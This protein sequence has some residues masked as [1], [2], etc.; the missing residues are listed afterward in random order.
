MHGKPPLLRPTPA[1]GP[2]EGESA[3]GRDAATEGPE[4]AQLLRLLWRRRL[5]ILAVALLGAL[6]V[7]ALVVRLEP[8]YRA[9]AV[10]LFQPAPQS[11][12]AEA[13]GL[14]LPGTADRRHVASEIEL[15]RSRGL[16]ERVIRREG[17]LYRAEF[18]P[19][20]D[21]AAGPLRRLGLR[22]PPGPETYRLSR[23]RAATLEALR[24]R[25]QVRPLGDSRAVEIAA[26]SRDPETAA[27]IAN[28]L[29]DTYLAETAAR[30]RDGRSAT[31]AW[32]DGRVA[33]LRAR[34]QTAEAAVTDF[35]LE[36]GLTGEGA[37]DTLDAERLSQLNSAVLEAAAAR[38]EAAARLAEAERLLDTDGAASAA[39]VLGSQLIRELRRQESELLRRRAELAINYGHRHPRMLTVTAELTDLRGKIDREVG[40]VVQHLRN[41][42][43]VARRREAE[44][45]GRLQAAEAE[46]AQLSRARVRLAQLEREA[47][48]ERQL[49]ETFLARL[50]ETRVVEDAPR[51]PAKVISRALPP[52]AP[53]APN[54]A[55]LLGFGALTALACGIALAVLVEALDRGVR[56]LPQLERLTGQRALALV[57]TVYGR[58]PPAQSVLS[59][60]AGAFAEALRGLHTALLLHDVDRPPGTLMLTSALPQEG[61]TTLACALA[62]LLARSGSRVLLVDADLRHPGVARTL[63]LPQG[64]GLAE[65]LAGTCHPAQAIRP[66]PAPETGGRLAVLTAG[67]AGA[68]GPVLESDALAKLLA[69][70]SGVYDLVLI[71]APPALA[72]AD[73]R[74]LA[75][76]VDATVLTVRWA[77]TPRPTVQHAVAQLTQAGATLAGLA[78]TRVDLRRHAR[79]GGGDSAPYARNGGYYDGA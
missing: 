7:G 28:A 11:G 40:R 79:Y 68:P 39:E 38:A 65:V 63:Y 27:G 60:P 48:A 22:A 55:L 51:A 10:L 33:E 70:W 32:L 75:H 50:K 66:D 18:N 17:L 1:P 37:G 73:S 61:K 24:S 6:V 20:L 45:S 8:R 69:A 77:T 47:A 34:V 3:P 26:E 52:G 59:R 29:A 25:L 54:R 58:T 76:R 41:E 57:P 35:R 14:L 78:L 42:A 31:S 49:F 53:A 36:S 56:N 19:I 72:V 2:A 62:R 30:A 16:L 64:P 44:L 74:A 67:R 46:A 71:D 15:M 21:G 43:A 9:T 5:L 23:Q 13:A 12:V 4:V